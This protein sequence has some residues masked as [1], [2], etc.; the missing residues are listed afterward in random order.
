MYNIILID[1]I[2]YMNAIPKYIDAHAHM[3]FSAY[4]EDRD[5]VIKRALD[6]DVWM[7]NVGTKEKT[8]KD[9]VDLANKYESGVYAIVGLHPVHT[10][11]SFHDK[12][13]I[14]EEGEPFTSSGEVFNF[15]FYKKLCEDKKV[16]G[17]GECGLDYY[18][19]DGDEKIYKEKQAAA[20][21]SQ[22]D[23]A[24]E[25]DLPLMIH[26]R[27]A[28]DDTLNILETYKKVSGDSLRG[29]FHFFAGSLEE[30]KRILDLG[31]TMSFTG[32]ITFTEDYR[33][34][35]EYLPID[36]ILSETDCP[37]V[38]PKPHRGK[39]NEPLHV[40]EV[41]KKIAEIKG[42]SLEETEMQ[43]V[44]NIRDFFKL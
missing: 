18:R 32:V 41:V 1:T 13:E 9:A 30:A 15:D 23:L 42:L 34:L 26:C 35:I 7:I 2:P 6:N 19:I 28:Y 37:Y 21:I 36:R 31:F 24:L 27:N 20:F 8:S 12:E 39:R 3:N 44:K 25:F 14:G 40:R 16:V 11:K 29:N 43:I 22:I 5:D 33:K 10:N 17:I 4:D 38:T